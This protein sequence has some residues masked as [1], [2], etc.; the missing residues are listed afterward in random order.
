[1]GTTMT[2]QSHATT[3]AGIVSLA[4][5]ASAPR[6]LDRSGPDATSDTSLVA[7]VAQ[8][9]RQA[10][11]VLFARHQNAVF[12]FV[13]RLTGNHAAAEDIVS[14]V[15]IDLWRQASA[16]EG[17]ARLSTWLFAV[18]RNKACSAMR[19]RTDEPLED[20]VAE[21]IPDDA[22]T[23]EEALGA[24]TRGAA[25]RDCLERLSPLHREIIDLVYYHE[26]SVEEC[27]AIVGAPVATVKT[28]VFYARRQLADLLRAAGI[29]TAQA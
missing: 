21:S 3:F 22:A 2:N 14:E 25:L 27:S 9:D 4:A 10:L 24:S 5:A 20:G 6:K 29:A 1:M 26:K 15:F 11:H 12:R 23:P 18:A 16:F 7:R 17:R 28:R 13:L 8:G 19:R